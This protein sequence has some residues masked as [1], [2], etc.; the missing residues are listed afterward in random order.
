MKI[1]VLVYFFCWCTDE[2]S[3]HDE[4]L[5]VIKNGFDGI[6]GGRGGGRG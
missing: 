3:I 6:G 4:L 2:I 1:L 5:K